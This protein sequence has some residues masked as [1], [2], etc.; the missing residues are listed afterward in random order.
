MN[1]MS[2]KEVDA[3]S[4]A[5]SVGSVIMVTA[6]ARALGASFSLGWAI[7]SAIYRVYGDRIQ[8]FLE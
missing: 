4:G 2:M 3:V 8:D 7:G 6:P 5:I 1:E